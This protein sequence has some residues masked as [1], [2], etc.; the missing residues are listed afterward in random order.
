MSKAWKIIL[1]TLYALSIFKDRAVEALKDFLKK[2]FG[3][4]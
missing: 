1:W 2:R 3:R 4:K